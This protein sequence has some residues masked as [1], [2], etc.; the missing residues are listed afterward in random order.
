MPKP[1]VTALAAHRKRQEKRGLA[2]VEVQ[3][4][5]SDAGLI[6]RAARSLRGEAGAAARVRTQLLGVLGAG[7]EPGLKELLASAP[8]DG[9]TLDRT[10]D[11]GR[12]VE[13]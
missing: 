4:P 2:R 11:R 9:I 12:A 1:R 7:T 8:L 5:A 10:P 6:R 3:V 13:L